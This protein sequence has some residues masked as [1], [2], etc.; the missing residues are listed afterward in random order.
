MVAGAAASQLLEA[1]RLARQSM[2]GPDSLQPAWK[3]LGDILLQFSAVPPLLQ[4]S[5]GL[6][7]RDAQFHLK[8]CV[9]T[10]VWEPQMMM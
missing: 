10:A 2:G 4:A 6:D 1:A 3:L 9:D 5:D 8:R 7:S